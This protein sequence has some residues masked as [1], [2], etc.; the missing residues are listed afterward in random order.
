MPSKT[1][2][3]REHYIGLTEQI[4]ARDRFSGG[5]F[6]HGTTI[7]NQSE[8]IIR[9]LFRQLLPSTYRVETGQLVFPP[10]IMSPQADVIIFRDVPNAIVGVSDSGEFLVRGEAAKVIIEVKRSLSYGKLNDIIEYA[11]KL[12]DSF[13]KMG[14]A[15]GTNLRWSQWAVAFR[16]DSLTG[17]GILKRLNDIY[18]PHHSVGLLLVLD[19]KRPACD[20]KDSFEETKGSA[21]KPTGTALTHFAN[22]MRVPNSVLFGRSNP[23]ARFGPQS[24]PS[25]PALLEFVSHLVTSLETGGEMRPLTLDPFL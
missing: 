23:S 15:T 16:S 6:S 7:G 19:A 3:L 12:H 14:V 9:D 11:T 22:S 2:D 21:K 17:N 4:L 24:D 1:F 20:I 18:H 25:I 8:N 13:D 10:D 5:M